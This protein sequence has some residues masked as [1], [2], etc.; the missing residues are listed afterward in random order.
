MDSGV[1]RLSDLPNGGGGG[2]MQNVQPDSLP[3]ISISEMKNKTDSDLPTNY[4]P[5]NT[6]PNPYGMS[7]QN[8]VMQHP[9]QQ[10]VPREN[11]Q[12]PGMPEEFRNQIMNMPDQRLPSRDIPIQTEQ[13]NIDE[14]VQP[15]YIPNK[16]MNKDYV[17]DHHDMTERNLR[18]YEQT[19][20]RENKLDSI[21]EDLQMPIFVA[22]LFF[23]FQLPFINTLIFKKFSFL[24]IYNDDGNFNFYGLLLKS[25]L[26]GNFY[27]FSNK[28]INFVS[29]L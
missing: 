4:A 23:L 3:T 16:E 6:H 28:V 17:R 10:N 11:F 21:L 7:E 9:E 20:Y 12:S 13:Y 15:N 1:T 27:L 19:K 29:T 14:R 8:P 25:M 26:F 2:N 22:L 18:E 5:L 24:S